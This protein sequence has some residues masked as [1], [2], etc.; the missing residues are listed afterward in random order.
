[1][2][3][4]IIP[5][6]FKRWFCGCAASSLLLVI[7]PG[8]EKDQDQDQAR[9]DNTI[10]AAAIT[11]TRSPDLSQAEDDIRAGNNAQA[12][13]RCETFLQQDPKSKFAPDAHYLLGKALLAQGK[14]E[15]AKK[16]FEKAI[17]DAQSRLLKGSAMLGRANCNLE[18]KNYHL[19][20]RQYHWL[21][22]MYRDVKGIPQDEVLFKCGLACKKAGNSDTANYWFRQ[23]IELYS[24]S[25]Y[26]EEA[27]RESSAYNPVDPQRKP[28]VYTLKVDTWNNRQK[29]DEEAEQLR[30][31][32]YRDVEV[33]EITEYGNK[34]YQVHVGKFATKNEA[35]RAETDA[36]LAGLKTTMSPKTLKAP[37]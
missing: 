17:D 37:E 26:A 24:M 7:L 5:Q 11:V 6:Q 36:E 19:A 14:P 18:L 9:A 34:A 3:N 28:L 8:C 20:S 22:S 2:S 12:Q 32:G 33:I 31:K 15:D 23:T 16:H 27:K 25:P 1:M 4:G 10:P 21:D 30:A 29:A 35:A 13:S